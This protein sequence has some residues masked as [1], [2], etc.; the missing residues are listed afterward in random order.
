MSEQ[1]RD[2]ETRALPEHDGTV[3]VEQDVDG[4]QRLP[5][6]D[7]TQRLTAPTPDR[8]DDPLAIFDEPRRTSEP[9]PASVPEPAP[10]SPSYAGEYAGR[11]GGIGAD[12]PLADAPLAAG[13]VTTAPGEAPPRPARTG[14]RAVTIVWGFLVLALGLGL[15]ADA[16]GAHIDV[17]LAAILLLSLAGLVLVVGSVVSAVRRRRS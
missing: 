2:D 16:A 5:V 13:P 10:S 4:T 3:P 6:T 11:S 9:A 1:N 15:V 14:P 7:D 12:G 17:E 8:S